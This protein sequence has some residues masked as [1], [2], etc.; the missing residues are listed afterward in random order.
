MC[1][2]RREK[3]KGIKEKNIKM[4]QQEVYEIKGTQRHCG[5]DVG[6]TGVRLHAKD[7]RG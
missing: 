5:R 2:S 3:R 6:D 4:I 7:T 1:I